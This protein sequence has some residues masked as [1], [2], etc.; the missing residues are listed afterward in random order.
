MI[1]LEYQI[2]EYENALSL[3]Y[4]VVVALFA[5]I[6]GSLVT[7]KANSIGPYVLAVISII[8]IIMIYSVIIMRS[9]IGLTKITLLVLKREE[10]FLFQDRVIVKYNS[11]SNSD[12]DEYM[13]F[14]VK[15]KE[16]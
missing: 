8:T 3:D 10:K 16:L 14:L 4:S 2:K 13:E 1:E 12:H 11:E 7:N 9:K 15:V 5:F 6:L